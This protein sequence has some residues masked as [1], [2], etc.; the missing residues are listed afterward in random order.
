M[1]G[2]P[3]RK[4]YRYSRPARPAR[5]AAC[6]ADAPRARHVPIRPPPRP[7][8]PRPRSAAT[9]YNVD[10]RRRRQ[11]C[12]SAARTRTEIHLRFT[13]RL[14]RQTTPAIHPRAR[15]TCTMV[16]IE[17]CNRGK[18]HRRPHSV[19][20]CGP[21]SY[22]VRLLRST[23]LSLPTPSRAG[24]R[25]FDPSTTPRGAVAPSLVS[26]P[27]QYAAPSSRARFSSESGTPV[28]SRPSAAPCRLAIGSK[29]RLPRYGQ[30][31]LRLGRGPAGLRPA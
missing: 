13:L 7:G 3:A 20:G 5:P 27:R 11:T 22:D 31:S 28:R 14:C 29:R 17:H 1:I 16:I 2:E 6:S 15:S 4:A 12:P 23:R 18:R 21:R 10:C 8:R 19:V 24:P 30:S 9:R 26:L 25:A